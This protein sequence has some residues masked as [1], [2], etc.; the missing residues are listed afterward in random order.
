MLPL[1]MTKPVLKR[2][3]TSPRTPLPLAL[4]AK[5]R[6]LVAAP[7]KVPSNSMIGVPAKS[8]SVR[9]SMRIVSLIVGSADSN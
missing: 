7:A 5:L 8:G 1:A 3:I 9:P 6:P 4:A 2:L